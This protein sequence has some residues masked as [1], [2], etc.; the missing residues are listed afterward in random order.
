MEML[1][2]VALFA[3][4]GVVIMNV[5]LLSLSAQRQTVARQN[6]TANLR[7]V[8]ESM[9]RQIRT[10]EIDYTATYRDDGAMGIQGSEK[11]LHL[12]D[13][14]GNSYA[15]FVWGG[16]LLVSYNGQVSKLTNLSEVKIVDLAF[17]IDPPTDPFLQERCND[18]MSPT[19]CLATAPIKPECTIDDVDVTERLGF[20]QC[21]TN[22]QCASQNCDAASGVCLPLNG[23]PRVTIV[24]SF[25]ST[26][27]RD[28]EMKRLHLQTTVV[29]RTYRR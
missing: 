18:K 2:V 10:G 1:I 20:C 23:Q 27:V 16:E 9:A 7:Y 17:Y 8:V 24:I 4:L 6:T 21:D 28:I 14:D 11:E 13:A 15:Y 19:G 3:M 22:D 12:R 29:S 25:E 5:Y 26:A